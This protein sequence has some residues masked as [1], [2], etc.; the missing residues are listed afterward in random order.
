MGSDASPLDGELGSEL[1]LE[2]PYLGFDCQDGLFS[3]LPDL[4]M[5]S[6]ILSPLQSLVKQHAVVLQGTQLRLTGSVTS[7]SDLEIS[8]IGPDGANL[9]QVKTYDE[10]HDL[11]KGVAKGRDVVAFRRLRRFADMDS[12]LG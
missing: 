1:L 8:G 4:V 12:D 11:L 10:L 9:F 5:V 6:T 3:H 7:R 2:V